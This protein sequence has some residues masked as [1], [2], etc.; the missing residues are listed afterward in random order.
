MTDEASQNPRRDMK[1]YLFEYLSN[2]ENPQDRHLDM[3]L[4]YLPAASLNREGV[5]K[6]STH[7][8]ER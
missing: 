6:C 4:D 8:Y 3:P 2:E 5:E 1:I 7:H